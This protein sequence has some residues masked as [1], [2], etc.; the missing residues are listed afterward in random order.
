MPRFTVVQ[1][2]GAPATAVWSVLVDWPRHGDW[3]PLTVVRVL[4]ER[5][6]GVGAEF[7]GRTQAGPLGFDDP[8]R[9]VGWEPPQGDAPGD[10]AGRCE[11]VKLGRVLRGRAWFTVTPLAGGRSRVAWFEDVTMIPHAVTRFA[12][13]LLS[14]PGRLAFAA[15]LRA[16][17]REVEGRSAR[18]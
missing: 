9:V 6:D 13:P 11:V 1:E 4:T 8:M 10:R 18:R 5:A 2:M 15:T 7:V 16:V 12:G 17:A 14:V 3:V